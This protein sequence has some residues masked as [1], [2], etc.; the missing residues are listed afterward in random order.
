MRSILS[1]LLCL[2]FKAGISQE[3]KTFPFQGGKVVYESVFVYDSLTK[4]QLHFRIKEWA[5]SNFNSQKAALQVDDKEI[6][7][8]A[9]TLIYNTSYTY[10]PAGIIRFIKT[11]NRAVHFN[12]K[13]YIK[14]YKLKL[15]ASDFKVQIEDPYQRKFGPYQLETYNYQDSIYL[16]GMWS[17]NK[18]IRE[19]AIENN[20]YFIILDGEIRQF[21]NSINDYL[22]KAKKSAFD[23]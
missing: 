8:L 6:G 11:E 9:Y 13:F 20:K 15:L 2:L 19:N 18:G 4:D 12:L 3:T 21:I 7:F 23:F 10:P 5:T 14:D 22:V 16:K 17:G 1:L